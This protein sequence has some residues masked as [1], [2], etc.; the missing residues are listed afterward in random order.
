MATLLTCVDE[1]DP[2]AAGMADHPI[3]R[4]PT[5]TLLAHLP[6]TRLVL[7]STSATVEQATAL[8]VELRRDYSALVV[9]WVHVPLTSDD[10]R[11]AVTAEVE[12]SAKHGPLVICVNSGPDA[13]RAVWPLVVEH[14]LG[15][16]WISVWPAYGSEHERPVVQDDKPRVA[17]RGCEPVAE[18]S[19]ATPRA[20]T[21][22]VALVCRQLGLRGEDPAFNQV[23][24]MA[25][26]L[27]PHP[28]P[29]L[30][31]GE[32]GTGKG[33]IAAL[34]HE[35]SGRRRAP[36]VAV[37]CAALP[38]TLVES[39]LFGHRKGAFTGAATDQPGKFALADGGTLFLDEI[40][41]LPLP[42]QAKLLRVLEDGVVEPIGAARGVAVD[43][44]IIAATHRDLKASVAEKTFREDLYFRLG[45]AQ[46]VLPPLR[47]RRGD[48]KLLALYQLTQLNR[49]IPAPR[50][51]DASAV[52]RLEEHTWPG[53]IRELANVLGRSV[54][55]S[56]H[57]ILQAEDIRID[58]IPAARVEPASLPEIGA[59]FS[60]ETYLSETRRALIDR[61]IQEAKGNKSQAA[62]LLGISPQAVHKYMR[63]A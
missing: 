59:G 37:N 55:L 49:S 43:I 14:A 25:A 61:A 27:A 6:V 32:T 29:L 8:E 36:F 15:A 35:M 30:I 28:V 13:L 3:G 17:A 60:L 31:Q 51:L 62:R 1:W 47:A 7:L 21:P 57:P 54:L 41:E 10:V 63:D 39:L 56:S 23:L 2:Y 40:G 38:E 45:Y 5:L 44:R 46:L 20:A 34:I 19:V 53:N 16:R 48:I 58:P 50:R 22:D 11:T 52:Q 9:E 42:V 24:E 4:G 26:R 12:Q 18:Y 33:M